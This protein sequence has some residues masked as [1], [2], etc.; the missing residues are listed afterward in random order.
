[1]NNCWAILKSV[2]ESVYAQQEQTGDY[3][4]M[5]DP[6]KAVFRLF[7]KAVEESDDDEDDGEL[8]EWLIN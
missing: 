5:R 3:I 7:K 1:M 8:W 2:V 4:Y 6:N